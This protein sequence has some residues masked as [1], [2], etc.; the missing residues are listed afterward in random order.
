MTVRLDTTLRQYERDGGDKQFIYDVTKSIG[1][2]SSQMRI[3]YKREGSVILDFTVQTQQGLPYNQLKNKIKNAI[4]DDCPY[5]VLGV[6]EKQNAVVKSNK[7]NM[8]QKNLQA[9]SDEDSE[10][11]FSAFR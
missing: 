9:S 7:F 8:F 5:P 6:K 4:Y 2:S 3:T 11:N 10:S 1:I